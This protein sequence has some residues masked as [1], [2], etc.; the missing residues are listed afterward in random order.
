MLF[1]S[2]AL[3]SGQAFYEVPYSFAP[4][5]RTELERG[6]IDCLVVPADAPPIVLEFK[7]GEPRPG[8][9]AQVERYAA[10]TRAILGVDRVETRILYA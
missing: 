10:A 7:T 6:V 3:A 8:H 9:A 2:A 1:R 4:A 5:D